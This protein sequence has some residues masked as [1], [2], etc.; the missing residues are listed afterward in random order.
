MKEYTKTTASRSFMHR[1]AIAAALGFLVLGGGAFAA[2]G[3]IQYV[4]S[5]FVTVEIDGQP[6]AIELQPVGENLYEGSLQTQT[7]DGRD[8]HVVVRRLEGDP[9]EQKMTV[10]V[11]LTG[12]DSIEE[13][14]QNI[15]VRRNAAPPEEFKLADLGDA[16]PAHEWS[17]AEGQDRALY[18]ITDEESGELQIFSTTTTEEE[19]VVRRV[20][21][22]PAGRHNGEPTISVDENDLITLTWA[23]GEGDNVERQVI[24]L[25]DRHTDKEMNPEDLMNIAGEAGDVKV[26]VESKE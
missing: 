13:R 11:N 3:G 17:N 16:V 9:N 14:E 23:T 21:M 4:K 8:A 1:P 2:G 7:Q 5:L 12:D 10:N 15:V 26:R 24:K 18:L 19:T 22:L 20:A 25:M 6:T